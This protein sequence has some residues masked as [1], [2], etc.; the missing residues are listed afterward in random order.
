[1]K[2]EPTTLDVVPFLWWILSGLVFGFLAGFLINYFIPV[3]YSS[4]AVLA[5]NEA[6]GIT[7]HLSIARAKWISE[8][9]GGRESPEEIRDRTILRT[10]KEGLEIVTR[11][12]NRES[13]RDVA[14]FAAML[15]RST[16]NEKELP[17]T[18]RPDPAL[19]K[20]AGILRSILIDQARKSGF[21]DFREVPVLASKGSEKAKTLLTNE[22]FNRRFTRYTEI[23]T[24]IG[25]WELADTRTAT[26]LLVQPVTADEPV[27]ASFA[28]PL[29]NASSYLGTLLGV[30]CGLVFARKPKTAPSE[31]RLSGPVFVS[32]PDTNEW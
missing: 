11:F 30:G 14:R 12:R 8:E 20:D 18:A 7:T 29:S 15:V 28:E 32:S 1:M 17:D 6:P 26:N 23:I 24:R 16:A 13:A 4:R 5:S 21:V 25:D 10:T 19:V 9:I 2:K 27:S 22:D 31:E 3:E